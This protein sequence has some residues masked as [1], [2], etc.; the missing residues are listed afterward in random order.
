[1]PPWAQQNVIGRSMSKLRP[2]HARS[3]LADR[4]I[5]RKIIL[6]LL[7][8]GERARHAQHATAKHFVLTGDA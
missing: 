5:D 2:W 7:T 1:M 6:Y 3:R 8:I 4:A